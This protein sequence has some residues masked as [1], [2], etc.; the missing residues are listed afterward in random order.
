MEVKLGPRSVI[1]LY[2]EE[3][4]VEC[5]GDSYASSKEGMFNK[6]VSCFDGEVAVELRTDLASPMV[7]IVDWD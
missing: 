7:P 1:R 5:R 4:G 2:A 3:R 6:L